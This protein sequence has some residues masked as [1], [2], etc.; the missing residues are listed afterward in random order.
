MS[1]RELEPDIEYQKAFGRNLKV[2]RG[3]V[4][5]TQGDLYEHSRV[6]VYQIGRIENG[7]EGPKFQTLLALAL[8]LGKKPAELFD[9]KY[10]LKPNKTFSKVNSQKPGTTKTLRGLLADNFFSKERTVGDVVNFT[11]E[12]FGKHI[13][14]ADVSGSLLIL[15]QKRQLEIIRKG[16][17]NYYKNA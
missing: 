16:N 4:G 2:L 3:S 10:A 8:A 9:F 17:K 6:S 14:S 12:K 13:K 15:A 7:N 5:W 1:R 11:R